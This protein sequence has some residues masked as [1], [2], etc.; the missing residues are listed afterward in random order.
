MCKAK[1]Y[2]QIAEPRADEDRKI[3]ESIATVFSLVHMQGRYIR[4][5]HFLNV[6]STAL[7][8]L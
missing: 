3:E 5:C 1:W 8:I 2:L 6:L 7:Y 4:N